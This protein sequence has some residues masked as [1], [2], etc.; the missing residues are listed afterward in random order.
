MNIHTLKKFFCGCGASFTRQ[1]TLT[2]H[3]IA[4]HDNNPPDGSFDMISVG[5]PKRDNYKCS[6]C[7]K[8]YNSRQALHLHKK[9]KHKNPNK[10][11]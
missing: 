3:F 7:K 8:I 6:P 4:V 2:R 5:R 9:I 11:K 10:R 1:H